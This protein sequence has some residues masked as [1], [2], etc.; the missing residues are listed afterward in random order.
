M[1]VKNEPPALRY[2]LALTQHYPAMMR[3]TSRGIIEVLD[4]KT[5][6]SNNSSKNETGSSATSSGA[7]HLHHQVQL[8]QVIQVPTFAVPRKLRLASTH[9][10]SSGEESSDDDA[11]SEDIHDLKSQDPFLYFSD[12]RRRL[13]YLTDTEDENIDQDNP[14]QQHH[15]VER[16]SQISFEVHPT[17]LLADLMT[18]MEAQDDGE[19]EEG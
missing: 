18:A 4:M 15:V 8:G 14:P 10:S 9:A 7:P 13:A 2:L 6:N 16:R 5:D 3:L 1:S 17:L 12:Q 11:S 19:E